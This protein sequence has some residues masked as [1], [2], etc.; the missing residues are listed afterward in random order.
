MLLSV[1][2]NPSVDI[3]Y[4]LDDF[5]LDEANR[6]AQVKKQPVEKD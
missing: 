2:L 1:T 3:S 6:V 5:Q 4:H